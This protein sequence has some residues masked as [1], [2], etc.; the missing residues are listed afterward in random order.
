MDNKSLGRGKIDAQSMTKEIDEATDR[1]LGLTRDGEKTAMNRGR[2]RQTEL[3]NAAGRPG[4]AQRIGGAA[5][6]M[7]GVAER[8]DASSRRHD[9]PDGRNGFSHEGR[10]FIREG[11]NFSSGEGNSAVADAQAGDRRQAPNVLVQLGDR[12][13]NLGVQSNNLNTSNLRMSGMGEQAGGGRQAIYLDAVGNNVPVKER[14]QINLSNQEL[15]DKVAKENGYFR[16]AEQ[17]QNLVGAESPRQIRER[18]ADDL[19]DLKD[20]ESGF[21]TKNQERLRKEVVDEI[22]EEINQTVANPRNLENAWFMGM[23]KMLRTSYNRNF[24]DRN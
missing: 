16:S 13:P 19:S 8:F 4:L 21:L 20:E 10:D 7:N 17:G 23:T 18:K 12:R 5:M 2:A 15:K 1:M 24:G 6:G 11:N 3:L 14:E 9:L 22:K